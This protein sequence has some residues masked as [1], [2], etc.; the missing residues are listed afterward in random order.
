MSDYFELRKII[1]FTVI[2]AIYFSAFSGIWCEFYDF[3][4]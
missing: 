3:G 1:D 4:N 2:P